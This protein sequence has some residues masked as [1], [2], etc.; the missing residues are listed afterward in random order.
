MQAVGWVWLASHSLPTIAL[1]DQLS[2][3]LDI[4]LV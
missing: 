1:C 3:T 2:Y 4:V